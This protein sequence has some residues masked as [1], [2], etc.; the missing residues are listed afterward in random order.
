MKKTNYHTHCT[1]CDGTESA[2]A[3]IEAAIARH[4]AVLGFSS[5][6]MYPFAA[7]WH[8]APGEHAAYCAEIR[9]LAAEYRNRIEIQLGFEADY[10]R[11]L[12]CPDFAR[13]AE[14]QPD[15]LIGSVHFITGDGGYTEADASSQEAVR[16]GIAQFF[17]GSVQ[18]WVHTYFTLQK[19]LLEKGHFTFLGH[20]DLI[21]K[22]NSPR[23]AEPLF[24]EGA[25]W[26]R[27]ELAQLATACRRADICVEINTGGMARGYLP[28]PYPSLELLTL[29][30]EQNVP[31][32]I[33]SDA[34]Q[35]RH[36]DYAFEQAA[37]HAKK[38]G[39]T[40]ICFRTAGSLHFQAI[41]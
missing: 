23:Y 37:A 30:R 18:E 35:S 16:E 11:G 39:Y 28:E 2:R 9:S 31:V 38:A 24:D 14:W 3:M 33:N 8:V 34:H 36:V 32:T 41:D 10:V 19:E 4:L 25:S 13:Y 5:H 12:C 22:Q 21:R 26:Y 17:G 7:D 1:Y 29:L 40:E 20:P 15:F 27:Q 6:S